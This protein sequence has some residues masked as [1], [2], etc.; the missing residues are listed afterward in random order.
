MPCSSFIGEPRSI[1]GTTTYDLSDSCTCPT[2]SSKSRRERNATPHEHCDCPERPMKK[3]SKPVLSVCPML[4]SYVRHW[5][6][7]L[8]V[9]FL[10]PEHR[11][12]G[13]CSCAITSRIGTPAVGQL[14]IRACAQPRSGAS[15]RGSSPDWETCSS[16]R[17]RGERRPRPDDLSRSEPQRRT[18][19]RG[20]WRHKSTS[21]GTFQG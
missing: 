14:P 1:F 15:G 13:G 9:L 18:C 8:V 2:C 6:M 11:G 20:S 21:L 10:D 19:M 7:S 3:C 17:V 12:P 4:A 16:A 5:V